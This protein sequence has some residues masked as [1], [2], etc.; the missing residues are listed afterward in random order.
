MEIVIALGALA[1][2]V[3]IGFVIW[4]WKKVSKLEGGFKANDARVRQFSA[5]LARTRTEEGPAASVAVPT[6]P[7]VE[8][9]AHGGGEDDDKEEDRP[10]T[11]E[12]RADELGLSYTEAIHSH[13]IWVLDK[14]AYPTCAF[15]E[16]DGDELAA[17]S[18][19]SDEE[20]RLVYAGTSGLFEGHLGCYCFTCGNGV[21]MNRRLPARITT[22]EKTD[23]FLL[24]KRWE[25]ERPAQ[26]PTSTETATAASVPASEAAPTAAPTA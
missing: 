13:T 23:L 12:E 25:N 3:S 9:A 11:L 21:T 17:C 1:L 15:S 6:A 5:D 24:F 18:C 4:L 10:H 7:P 14:E 22:E 2:V 16:D 19:C 26:P 8:A 20:I